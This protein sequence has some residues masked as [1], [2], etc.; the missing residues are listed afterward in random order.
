MAA[1]SAFGPEIA[2][3]AHP[4]FAVQE[5]AVHAPEDAHDLSSDLS[6]DLASEWEHSLSIDESAPAAELPAKAALKKDIAEVVIRYFKV[7][8]PV[9]AALG[10]YVVNLHLKDFVV[11]RADGIHAYQLAVA[12]DDALMGVTDVLRGDDLLGST[13]RQILLI[14]EEEKE[15]AVLCARKLE[16]GAPRSEAD[17]RSPESAASG[18]GFAMAL[19]FALGILFGARRR[20]RR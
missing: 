16:G 4:E 20:R 15:L 9:V 14:S 13:P 11:R 3:A 6:S 10:P 2:A 17:S 19:T 8:A 12:V 7:A 18:G 5:M 1:P